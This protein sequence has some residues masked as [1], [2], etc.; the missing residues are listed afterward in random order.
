M[1]FEG[2]V[3]MTIQL[4]N[5]L[6]FCS[7]QLKQFYKEDWQCQIDGENVPMTIVVES[8]DMDQ[9]T[10]ESEYK[11]YPIVPEIGL[12]NRDCHI[13]ITKDMAGQDF[14]P[15]SEFSDLYDVRSY[16]GAACYILDEILNID[17]LNKN[18]QAN[19][20][21]SDACLKSYECRFTGEIKQYPAFKTHEACL[22]FLTALVM[23]YGDIV[24]AMI[25]FY[26]DKPVNLVGNTGWETVKLCLKGT[27]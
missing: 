25:G 27:E 5:D 16:C 3:V 21:I 20:K 11:D 22:E 6:D 12:L 26:L 24:M 17:K 2:G 18:I 1:G 10:G 13:S 23:K 15:E 14:N 8:L 4:I 19:L 7:E 9:I